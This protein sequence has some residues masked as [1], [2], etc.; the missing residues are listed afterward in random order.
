MSL[1]FFWTACLDCFQLKSNK[2]PESPKLWVSSVIVKKLFNPGVL[3]I[4]V[5]LLKSKTTVFVC[6][7]GLRFWCSSFGK[8]WTSNFWQ[9]FL[10]GS[11][12]GIWSILFCYFLCVF[13]IK[14]LIIGKA[15]KSNFWKYQASSPC[16]YYLGG[17]VVLLV[18]GENEIV[19]LLKLIQTHPAHHH[20][21][22][23]YHIFSNVLPSFSPGLSS[24]SYGF[25]NSS[26]IALH[27]RMTL[28]ITIYVIIIFNLSIPIGHRAYSIHLTG[29]ITHHP[30]QVN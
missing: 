14:L 24:V 30:S 18:G 4:R 16:V 23:V 9:H 28:I 8:T 6:K 17:V 27:S 10:H 29:C 12:E 11:W 21:P 3:I 7:K 22:M 25:S 20:V 1:F 15:S 26:H 5:R 13:L 2:R 19:A